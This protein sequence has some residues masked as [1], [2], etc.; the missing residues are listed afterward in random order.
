M[1]LIAQF[2][3]SFAFFQEIRLS[4]HFELSGMQI[5]AFITFCVLLMLGIRLCVRTRMVAQRMEAVSM[6]RARVLTI[7]FNV[8]RC[9]FGAHCGDKFA[10]CG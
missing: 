1:A 4:L 8:C 5:I 9:C 6:G 7:S 2:D 3:E 10:A